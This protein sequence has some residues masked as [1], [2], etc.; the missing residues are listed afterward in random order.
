[1][2]SA[3]LVS[4]TTTEAAFDFVNEEVAYAAWMQLVLQTGRL[5]CLSQGRCS[6]ISYRRKIYSG[7]QILLGVRTAGMGI[8]ALVYEQIDFRRLGPIYP[9]DVLELRLIDEI[10][11]QGEYD[12]AE[13]I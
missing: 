12:F 3:I 10:T 7:W 8:S 13:K 2:L 9:I 6:G 1:V 11:G 4:Q 5:F